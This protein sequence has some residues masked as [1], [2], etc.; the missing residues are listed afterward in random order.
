MAPK[1]SGRIIPFEGLPPGW[2]AIEKDYLTGTMAGKTYVRFQNHKNRN[3]CSVRAA[4]KCDAADR[5]LDAEEVQREYDRK[6]DEA[7]L[8]L[9]KE[10]EARGFLD[11]EKRDQAA[12][13]FRERFGKLE[14][15]TI[16]AIPGWRGESKLLEGSGQIA[17]RYYS[18]EGQAYP[19]VINIEAYFGLKMMN[20]EEVPDIHAARASV[21]VDEHGKAVNI[22]RRENVQN[23]YSDRVGTERAPKKHKAVVDLVVASAEDYRETQCLKIIRLRTPFTTELLLAEKLPEQ[24]QV[25]S[26]AD[27]VHALLSSCGFPD[28]TELLYVTGSRNQRTPG[29]VRLDALRGVYYQRPGDYNGRPYFQK[30]FMTEG[31]NSTFACGG[32]F[33]AWSTSQKVWKIGGLDESKAGFAIHREDKPHPVDLESQWLLYEPKNQRAEEELGG[34]PS[35]QEA[36]NGA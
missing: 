10:R 36:E 4:L 21:K 34:E 17:A 20:G 35:Q 11:P 29:R 24:E 32:H 25:E 18:P 14:G 8:K 15:A 26:F 23:D 2:E 1:S 9:Q 12:A 7:K 28:K 31:E 6:K 27:Q 30:V 16:C 19:L 3:V 13:V 5:G 33:L 22:A